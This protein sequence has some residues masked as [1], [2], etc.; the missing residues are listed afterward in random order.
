MGVRSRSRRIQEPVGSLLLTCFHVYPVWP[1]SVSV[2]WWRKLYSYTVLCL[3]P[4]ACLT[5]LACTAVV[6]YEHSCSY[7]SQFT[8]IQLCF[9]L[10]FLLLTAIF[11][12]LKLVVRKTSPKEKWLCEKWLWDTNWSSKLRT[13]MLH[14]RL[15]KIYERPTLF[16]IW[17]ENVNEERNLWR[18]TD[19]R[20]ILKQT[21]RGM[22]TRLYCST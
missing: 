3:Q 5:Q 19:W 1:R 9:G 4:I 14:Y 16:V 10:V 13:G 22:Y 17:Y 11:S 12:L 18:H 6:P 20:I 8:H 2:D 15:I 7:L 21:L